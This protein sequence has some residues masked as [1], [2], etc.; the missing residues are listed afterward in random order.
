MDRKLALTIQ[1]AAMDKLSGTMRKI[2]GLGDSG[3]QALAKMKREAR[4]LDGTL[5]DVRSRLAAGSMQGG[6]LMAERELVKAIEANNRAIEQRQRLI[7][8]DNRVGKMHAKADSYKSAGQENMVAGAGMAAPIILAGKAAMDFSSGMVDI[9][10]KA[11]MTNAETAKMAAGIIAAARATNQMPEDMRASV[12]VLSGF[13]MDPRQA[14]QLA[15]PIGRLGT[16]FKVDLA[17]GA[18]AA[19]ANVNNLK[20]SLA[21]TGKAFDIMAAG[22]LAGAFEVKDMAKQ[23]PALTARMQALGQ[24]GVPA[25]ADLT[26]A[27]QVA[28][29][30]AGNADEAGNNIQNLLAKINAPS[31]IKAFQKNFEVDLPAAMKKFQAQGMTSMEAFAMVANKATGGD[32]KKLAFLVEDQQAQ[33]ALL[34][35][36]QNMDKYRQIRSDISNAGGTVDRAFSQRQMNDA[37]VAWSSFKGQL[38]G[39]AIVLGTNVLPAATQFLGTINGMIGGFGAWAQANPRL[40][41]GLMTFVATLAMARIGFGALQFAFGAILGPMATAWGWFQKYRAL[42]SIASAFPKLAQGF[43]MV[44]TA[45]I[46]MAQGVM[47]AGAM[48]L[49]NPMV[50][51]V[52]AI[53]AVLVGAGHLIYR[54]WDKIN[55]A[56]S[57]GVAWV[58]E[59][60]QAFKGAISNGW[61]SVKGAVSSGISAVSDRFKS[62]P[63]WAQ[64]ALA[65]LNPVT[66]VA[67]VA[68]H[69]NQVKGAVAAGGAKIAAGWAAV[70]GAFAIGLGWIQQGWALIR[71]GF[72]AGIAWLGALPGQMVTIGAQIIQGLVNGIRAAPGAVWAALKSIVLAG[73]TNIRAFLGIKSPSRLFMG[74]G[75]FMTDG[76]AI[77]IDKGSRKP[78]GAMARLAAGTAAAFTLPAVPALAAPALPNLAPLPLSIAAPDAPRL[79][80]M[81]AL[82]AGMTIAPPP[83]P[84]LPTMPGFSQV[85]VSIA[86]PDAPRM[87]ALPA[88]HSGMTI[89]PPAAPRL[90][91]MP[92]FSPVP[93]SIAAPDAP[94]MPTLPAI[95]TGM[96]IAPPAP[97]R[98]PTMPGFSPVPVSI[99]APDAPRMPALPALR[100]GM[101][102][103]PP[104]A[105][106]LPTMPGFSPVPVSITAPDAPRMPTLPAIRTGM[107][108]APPAPPRLP[109]MPGFSPVPVSIAAPDAPRMPAMP[110]LRAGMTIAPP[111]APR[112][113][114]MPGFS[115]VPVSIAAPDAP[116]LPA[117]PALRAG[118]TIA[119]PPAP[120]LPT[121]PGFSPV[122]VS[123]A[124]PDAPRLPALPALRA[125]MTIAPP[126]APRM[127]A[128]A[129]QRI[130]AGIDMAEPPSLPGLAAKL[131]RLKLPVDLG[132]IAAPQLGP[133]SLTVTPRFAGMPAL[134]DPLASANPVPEKRTPMALPRTAGRLRSA[135]GPANAP[136]S[137]A[138]QQ[139][140]A[141]ASPVTINI[142]Q[143]PGEDGE[144]L[145][146]R[147]SAMLRQQQGNQ[148]RGAYRDE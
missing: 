90:P 97:P 115:P 146:R 72:S 46:F 22:G 91:T 33:M 108:I 56:F 147:I 1:F 135:S 40:A 125:G 141:P 3:T 6:L 77:G 43:G 82:R 120:R 60:W 144:A 142:Y 84:R 93:V 68:T 11:A 111:P 88:L 136:A 114:T 28:M 39:T 81:P 73:I 124:A 27:L 89:S 133:I 137:G 99:A 101:T 131:G 47:R 13:G 57:A 61:S 78:L 26:A 18:A 103:A 98:L 37:S 55:A 138:N 65:A 41:S 67:M 45:S 31:V 104:A 94:R 126:A 80:A 75:G 16:A 64:W 30:T 54:N 100:S 145:A 21:D 17:D 63:P 9:Q 20:L 14:A 132:D 49:A 44:R 134:P 71:S 2:V 79:P 83:V 76:L 12:D 139:Q 51:A 86:A 8:I 50:L 106:R 105:P 116:R 66:M 128:F 59:K 52:V 34:A 119:P 42:G 19:Y 32:T 109:T 23:F 85:P 95:R 107:T 113:P 148:R 38:Q 92:G 69:W 5:K 7:A 36:I 127:P 129:A 102:I 4:E 74:I 24:T 130:S 117:L 123:I 58:G 48:M 143:Q 122:P 110:A 62:L 118:M 10:Q 140:A 121:M 25:V 96:T 29:N 53:G 70:K 35:L 112:L 15:Q 87:P